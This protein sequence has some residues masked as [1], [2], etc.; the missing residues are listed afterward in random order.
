MRMGRW[1]PAGSLEDCVPP[2]C[3]KP[4]ANATTPPATGAGKGATI[5]LA[6][7]GGGNLKGVIKGYKKRADGSTTTYFDRQ[8]P[9]RSPC[10]ARSHRGPHT[11]GKPAERPPQGNGR[12]VTNA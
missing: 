9:R 6:A 1:N 12:P 8:V 4:R 3:P 2:A 11:H 7:K 10:R 5:K